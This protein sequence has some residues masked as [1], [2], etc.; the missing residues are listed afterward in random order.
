MITPQFEEQSPC[1][2]VTAERL[3]Q[4]PGQC[5]HMVRFTLRIVARTRQHR[6]MTMP[7]EGT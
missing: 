7:G 5:L 1:P 3:L 2:N 6:S 4:T